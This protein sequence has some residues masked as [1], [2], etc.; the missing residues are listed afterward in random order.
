MG[1]D[2]SWSHWWGRIQLLLPTTWL[3]TLL[4]CC[5]LLAGFSVRKKE[6]D[7]F[8]ICHACLVSGWRARE[9]VRRVQWEQWLVL[10]LQ[11]VG[12]LKKKRYFEILL[13]LSDTFY[14]QILLLIK[15]ISTHA[16][17]LNKE[18]IKAATVNRSYCKKKSQT[19]SLFFY[20]ASNAS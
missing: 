2:S 13:K 5:Q 20:M 4:V 17:Q 15:S 12:K 1:A 8:H 14:S 6:N 11:C 3:H 9:R 7:L 19:H 18:I 16:T 10:W